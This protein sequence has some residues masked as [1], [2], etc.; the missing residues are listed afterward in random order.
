LPLEPERDDRFAPDDEPDRFA[1]DDVPERLADEDL[2][3]RFA[4]PLV[5]P[6]NDPPR[7]E[8]DF[9]AALRELVVLP[10]GF[11]DVF[12]ELLLAELFDAVR[13][14]LPARLAEV[15]DEDELL[16]VDLPERLAEDLPLALP[17]DFPELF[18][19]G[20]A[21][22]APDLFAEDKVLDDRLLPPVD[23]PDALPLDLPADFRDDLPAVLPD[24]FDD[25]ADDL[26]DDFAEDL[27][28]EREPLDLPE[29]PPRNEERA[30]PDAPVL[31]PVGPAPPGRDSAAAGMI[32]S[33]AVE[34]PPIA[35]PAAA[36]VS[37]SAA[38]SITLSRMPEP[39]DLSEPE[40]SFDD[41]DPPPEPDEV[42]LSAMY[43][44]PIDRD[45][46]NSKFKSKLTYIKASAN[47]F[48]LA[49]RY[50]SSSYADG[51]FDRR[52]R[53][54]GAGT[55][56]SA[57]ASWDRLSDNRQEG[58][59]DALFQGDRRAGPHA[60]DLRAD[61][62]RGRAGRARL[63]REQGQAARGRRDSR[64]DR[65]QLVRRG[66]EPVPFPAGRRAGQARDTRL[67]THPRARW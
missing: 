25:F 12:P 16:P 55:R 48:F 36:P 65:P 23:L 17:L 10:L 5:R 11:A 35:A 33:A 58:V 4:D 64:A 39:C 18:P 29:L 27:P 31:P 7:D 56:G 37:I 60:G 26:P 62:P 15:R 3:V 14:E 63:D 61:R 32:V 9:F 59:D 6:L 40:F 41:D 67:R 13:D 49:G 28:P 45:I 54:H 21:L 47:T 24:D 22:D 30:V 50:N 34:T 20:F 43:G 46:S 1:D 52:R 51:R 57:A 44:P 8:V 66:D 19:D 42:E 2:A 38:A 53:T